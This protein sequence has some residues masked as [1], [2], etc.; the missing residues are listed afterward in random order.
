[1]SAVHFHNNTSLKCSS[2][3][4]WLWIYT[5]V[6]CLWR[7]PYTKNVGVF[8]DISIVFGLPR[9]VCYIYTYI[10]CIYTVENT[11]NT[12]KK[13]KK[14][15]IF[16]GYSIKVMVFR[17]FWIKVMVFRG[18]WIK[19]TV[20]RGYSIIKR[21]NRYNNP[22]FSL[23]IINFPTQNSSFWRENGGY[24]TYFLQWGLF[25]KYIYTHIVWAVELLVN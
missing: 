16:T 6:T 5:I 4:N 12:M 24:C 8:L 2:L 18:F 11:W 14:L 10:Y 21:K 1:M 7:Y 3:M 15:P 20:F 22:I 19:V 17:G 9:V 23:K 13:E 25:V